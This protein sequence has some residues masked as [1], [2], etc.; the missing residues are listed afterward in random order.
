MPDKKKKK[1]YRIPSA[2]G[3]YQVDRKVGSGAFG[4]VYKAWDPILKRDVAIKV[5]A[6]A[7]KEHD[8]RTLLESFKDEVEIAAQFLHPNIVAIYD[9]GSTVMTGSGASNDDYVPH[10]LVMEYIAAADLKCYLSDVRT[11]PLAE[12]IEII[13][14]CCKA[15]DFMHH[16]GVVHRDIKPANIL[17]NPELHIVKLM[18]F[19]ISHPVDQPKPRLLGSPRYMAPEHFNEIYDITP[20]TDI[21]ALGSVMYE[22]LSGVPAFDGSNVTSVGYKIE[23]IEPPRLSEI[24]PD[25]PEDIDQVLAIA[26]NKDPA[27]RY[28]DALSFADALSSVCSSESSSEM[29]TFV[30]SELTEDMSQYLDIR[31]DPF[32]QKFSPEQIDDLLA[33]AHIVHV[34]EGE[35]I[36]REGD[37]ATCSYLYLEGSADVLRK[38]HVIG[39][40]E[41]GESFGEAAHA[42]TTLRVASIVASKSSKLLMIDQQKLV[43]ISDATR[44]NLYKLMFTITLKRLAER[45]D[46]VVML[47]AALDES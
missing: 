43:D 23:N 4:D 7:L 42:D 36:V 41:A 32:F 2:I 38:G 17:V 11:M 27:Q 47:L 28:P 9:V 37:Q 18:D 3:R 15:L 26:M 12:A 21:F 31:H 34:D 40:L 44:A 30:P 39:K 25:L 24:N 46:E 45:T 29:K 10:Y 5:P 20:A 35:H 1:K 22:M 33:A 19:T 6:F 16:R 13:Y 14:S 8:L